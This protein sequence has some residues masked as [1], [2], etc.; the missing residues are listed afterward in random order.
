MKLTDEIKKELTY[1]STKYRFRPSLPEEKRKVLIDAGLV[2]V[3]EGC[4]ILSSLGEKLIGV[5]K[6][7]LYTNNEEEY[8]TGAF[9]YTD[10]GELYE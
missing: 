10:E 2:D 3:T 4:I 8:I 5:F 7:E 1:I 9:F 6:E